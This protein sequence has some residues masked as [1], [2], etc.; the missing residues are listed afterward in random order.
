[1]ANESLGPERKHC[2]V[3]RKFIIWPQALRVWTAMHRSL[4][5]NRTSYSCRCF[6][7]NSAEHWVGGV[8]SCLSPTG[9]L[10]YRY[11]PVVCGRPTDRPRH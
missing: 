2:R 10:L 6:V 1:M 9:R 5:L 3:L 11:A 7:A 4:V 8:R